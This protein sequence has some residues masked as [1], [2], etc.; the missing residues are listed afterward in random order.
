MSKQDIKARLQ[1][2]TVI[3]PFGYNVMASTTTL[4]FDNPSAPKGIYLMRLPESVADANRGEPPTQEHIDALLSGA[5]ATAFID[6]AT[7]EAVEDFIATAQRFLN[8]W[9]AYQTQKGIT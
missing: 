6:F 9:R 8:D 2:D 4:D 5:E 7:P 1:E 3:L